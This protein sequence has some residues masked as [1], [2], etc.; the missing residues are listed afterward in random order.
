MTSENPLLVVLG[1]DWLREGL[2][3]IPTSRNSNGYSTMTYL[4]WHETDPRLLDASCQS[5]AVG[6]GGNELGKVDERRESVQHSKLLVQGTHLIRLCILVIP[7][8]S[9]SLG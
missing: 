5:E 6:H 3:Y 7:L 1:E 2:R 8:L 9:V 4:Q